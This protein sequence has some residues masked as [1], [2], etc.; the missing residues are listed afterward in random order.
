MS[1][2]A[3]CLTMD[4][5]V[6]SHVMSQCGASVSDCDDTCM[7][8]IMQCDMCC[9]FFTRKSELDPSPSRKAPQTP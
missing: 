2:D 1:D 9:A 7:N 6:K 4:W 5:C 8:K 3:H